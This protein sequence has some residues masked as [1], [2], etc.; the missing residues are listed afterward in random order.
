[1]MPGFAA[2]RPT[3]ANHSLLGRNRAKIDT[4]RLS[5]VTAAERITQKSN[6]SS[7]S[8]ETRVFFSFA[9]SFS[10]AIMTRI[11]DRASS[12]LPRQQIAKSSA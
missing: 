11:E 6:L 7:G 3:D 2:D 8:F 4:S 10:F 1:M 9:V 12:A 5:R